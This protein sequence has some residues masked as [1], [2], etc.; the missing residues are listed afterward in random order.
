[1]ERALGL[2]RKA[3]NR[4]LRCVDLN[5]LTRIRRRA[6]PGPARASQTA[7]DLDVALRV[8]DAYDLRAASVGT[9]E[10][11][12][13]PVTRGRR[14]VVG[15]RPRRRLAGRAHAADEDR[16]QDGGQREQR[17]GERGL[18]EPDPAARFGLRRGDHRAQ[19]GHALVG[20]GP[21]VAAALE[22]EQRGFDAAGVARC[23]TQPVVV[24]RTQ[25][26]LGGGIAAAPAV[27]LPE[28]VEPPGRRR[29]RLA[30]GRELPG[31][32]ALQH[33]AL[34]QEHDEPVVAW[35]TQFGDEPPQVRGR[36]VARELDDAHRR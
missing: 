33:R 31:V 9:A 23:A 12:R 20:L 28:E 17:H 13:R 14:W 18:H 7:L 32:F 3:H 36:D 19:P 22:R 35:R 8:Q 5:P 25:L 21:L 15:R 26:E 29:Q 30:R 6:V 10:R 1:M 27:G 11:R 16:R 2:G 24:R 4:P 34:G